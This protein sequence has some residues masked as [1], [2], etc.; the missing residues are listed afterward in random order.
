MLEETVNRGIDMVAMIQTWSLVLCYDRILCEVSCELRIDL[1]LTTVCEEH[2]Y[3]PEQR[4]CY[5][6]II[7]FRWSSLGVH[8]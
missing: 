4:R 5:K 1:M 3:C 7:T 6:I 2:I 8:V